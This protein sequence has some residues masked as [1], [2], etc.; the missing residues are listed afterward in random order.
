M[1]G[2]IHN[3]VAGF[4]EFLAP[5]WDG[6]RFDLVWILDSSSDNG[7]RLSILNHRGWIFNAN[8]G[9]VRQTRIPLN[10]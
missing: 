8:L 1:P 3:I 6:T 4:V 10:P 2:G 5:E 7:Y 9:T